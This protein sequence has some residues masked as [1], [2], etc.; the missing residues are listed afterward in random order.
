[1]LKWACFFSFSKNDGFWAYFGGL[2]VQNGGKNG[3][4]W[5]IWAWTGQ[6]GHIPNRSSPNLWKKQVILGPV[7][8][9]WSDG[10]D[11]GS[12]WPEV[13][14]SDQKGVKMGLF[15]SSFGMDRSEVTRVVLNRA[16]KVAYFSGFGWIDL[17]K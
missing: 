11:R 1:M 17:K 15:L 3:S 12:N 6:I 13:V 5:H 8:A 14:K 2:G 4:K 7:W 10:V 16:V 9:G